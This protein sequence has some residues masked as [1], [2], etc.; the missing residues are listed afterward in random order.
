LLV[1]RQA[2]HERGRPTRRTTIT[3]DYVLSPFS[4]I[5]AKN[6]PPILQFEENGSPI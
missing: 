3:G 2:H 1:V 4:E 5:A 6:T